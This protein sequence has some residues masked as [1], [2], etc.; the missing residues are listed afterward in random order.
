MSEPIPETEFVIFCAELT[1][2]IAALEH[3]DPR[4]TTETELSQ[5]VGH[6]IVVAADR[7]GLTH[8]LGDICALL[9]LGAQRQKSGEA[10]S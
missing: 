10:G 7:A 2:G 4:P 1:T 6:V 9:R 3:Q 8:R 5:A